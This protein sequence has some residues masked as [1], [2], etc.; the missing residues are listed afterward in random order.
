MACMI[1]TAYMAYMPYSNRQILKILIFQVK[2]F[3]EVK[4]LCGRDPIERGY[5]V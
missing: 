4:R 1:K 2:I 5:F 3:V